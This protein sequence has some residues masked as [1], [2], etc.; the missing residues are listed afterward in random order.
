MRKH[1]F[2]VTLFG[3]ILAVSAVVVTIFRFQLLPLPN[4]FPPETPR[5]LIVRIESAEY[6]ADTRQL[7]ADLKLVW[8][9]PGEPPAVL[10]VRREVIAAG[11]ESTL[12]SI[13]PEKLD[14]PFGGSRMARVRLT[15]PVTDEFRSENL[16]LRITDNVSAAFASETAPVL[17]VHGPKSRIAL[18]K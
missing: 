14:S 13:A 16:Y 5:D 1:V 18:Q 9:G 8:N 7:T 17:L 6:N 3:F 2:G 11:D 15:S 12:A 10:H 4:V